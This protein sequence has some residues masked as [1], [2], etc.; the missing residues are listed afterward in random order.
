[1][2]AGILVLWGQAKAVAA[3]CEFRKSLLAMDRNTRLIVVSNNSALSLRQPGVE[4][5]LWNNQLREFGAWDY[6][7]PL[8]EPEQRQ[9]FRLVVF[10]ND[11]FMF[12]Q[13]WGWLML[14]R[15]VLLAVLWL[16]VVSKSLFHFF[17]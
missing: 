17:A 16:L 8:I 10:G 4:L 6:G 2:I 12:Y 5:A 9:R 11:T 13:Q 15:P 14:S 1:M 3:V 7:L